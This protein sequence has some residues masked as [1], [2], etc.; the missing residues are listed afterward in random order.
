MFVLCF[1]IRSHIQ[2]FNH[3]SFKLESFYCVIQNMFL[4]TFFS[5]C[6]CY[7]LFDIQMDK[8]LN[9]YF[10][11]NMHLILRVSPSS[12]TCS[13]DDTNSLDGLYFW[14]SLIPGSCREM[15]MVIQTTFKL[16]RK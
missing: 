14:T 10:P 3:Q 7:N 11:P 1:T 4:S 13:V 12:D 15:Q 16:Y 2:S 6:L 9:V 8:S 5:R